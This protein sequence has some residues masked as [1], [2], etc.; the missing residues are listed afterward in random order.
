MYRS[1]GL[2]KI[3]QNGFETIAISEEYIG[4][5]STGVGSATGIVLAAGILPVI[6][7]GSNNAIGLGINNT[8]SI[9][10]IKMTFEFSKNN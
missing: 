9:E 6:N 7:I 1:L 3:S 4:F 5:I 8:N 2:S 10:G